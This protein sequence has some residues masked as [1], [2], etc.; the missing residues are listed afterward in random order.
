M[1]ATWLNEV[2]M[3]LLRRHRPVGGWRIK[4]R[5][6]IIPYPTWTPHVCAADLKP[7]PDECLVMGALRAEDPELDHAIESGY[8]PR[9]L[10]E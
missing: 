1:N 7:W 10:R 5:Y 9:I 8:L 4:R 6:V 2:Q 3:W